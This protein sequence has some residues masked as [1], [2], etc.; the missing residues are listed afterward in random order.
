MAHWLIV[1]SSI[2]TFKNAQASVFR[3]QVLNC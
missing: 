3:L 2:A 1:A